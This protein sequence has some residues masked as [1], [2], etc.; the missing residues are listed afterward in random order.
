[1]R[2]VWDQYSS[3]PETECHTVE[4]VLLWSLLRAVSLT[5]PGSLAF[6]VRTPM[7]PNALGE[8]SANPPEVVDDSQRAASPGSVS[9]RAAARAKQPRQFS[10][11]VQSP[12]D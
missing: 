9:Q 3:T 5:A 6:V 8:A 12:V 1:M 10:L 11:Q 7:L 2:Q 4:S